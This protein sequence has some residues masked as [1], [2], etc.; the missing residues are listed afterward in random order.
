[1]IKANEVVTLTYDNGG[2]S[3][4]MQAKALSGG[5]SPST[6]TTKE[7]IAFW[8]FNTVIVAPPTISISG[9]T[10]TF[11]GTLQSAATLGGAFA[12]V[13]GATSP[14]TIPAETTAQYY[15]ASQ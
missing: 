2:V 12:P 1:M 4:A 7:L 9:S 14:Y 13:A 11:T 15:R 6:L 10:I 5:A 3:L 8:D